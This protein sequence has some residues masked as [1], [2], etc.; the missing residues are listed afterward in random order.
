MKLLITPQNRVSL[1]QGLYLANGEHNISEDLVLE[2]PLKA[3]HPLQM[4]VGKKIGAFTY[5]WSP[6]LH[7]TVEVG[8]YC[9]IAPGVQIAPADHPI[10][11]LTTSNLSWD[12]A[13]WNDGLTNPQA[14]HTP[15]P[16]PKWEKNR[17]GTVSIGNDVWIGHGAIIKQGVKIGDGAIIGAYAVVTKDVPDFAVV[18]GLP[19]KIIRYRFC[20]E[21]I[22][23]LRKLRWWD[24]GIGIFKELTI[25]DI[26]LSLDV[27]ENLGPEALSKYPINSINAKELEGLL[28][29][30]D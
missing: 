2:Y 14:A 22:V 11:Y 7:Q 28:I 21:E 27:I 26:S 19:G 12:P 3:Y 29:N 30:A 6:F 10:D 24:Y 18:A 13:Y 5:S 9:S 20:E 17:H 1:P 16:D 23:R 4:V 15:I 25:K 8:R